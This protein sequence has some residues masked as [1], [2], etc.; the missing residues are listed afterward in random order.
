MS[1]FSINGSSLSLKNISLATLPP[2]LVI[3]KFMLRKKL[4][5]SRS[6]HQ[7]AESV[8]NRAF[9]KGPS[10]IV[11]EAFL[12]ACGHG[13]VCHY[14]CPCFIMRKGSLRYTVGLF[15]LP[16]VAL[17]VTEPWNTLIPNSKERW[18]LVIHSAPPCVQVTQ[19][20]SLPSSSVPPDGLPHSSSPPPPCAQHSNERDFLKQRSEHIAS[21]LKTIRALAVVGQAL[22]ELPIWPAHAAWAPCP[23]LCS[24]PA[25]LPALLIPGQCLTWCGHLLFPL[26]EIL[27]PPDVCLAYALSSPRC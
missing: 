23:H 3:L 11:P 20:Y 27:F 22:C 13:Q 12:A 15:L 6:C 18:P 26:L 17:L 24:H 1:S 5:V 19:H 10:L 7:A 14:Y 25:C 16:H 2:E 4:L 8:K 21:L 9:L